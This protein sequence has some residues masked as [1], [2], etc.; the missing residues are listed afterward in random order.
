MNEARTRSFEGLYKFLCIKEGEK[1][2]HRLAKG[3]KRKTKDLGQ[4]K[5]IRDDE[6]KVSVQER[7]IKDRWKKYFHKLFNE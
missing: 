6:G 2:I 3:R 7:D 4:M 5:C 1:F